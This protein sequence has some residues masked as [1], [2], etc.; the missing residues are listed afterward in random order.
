MGPEEDLAILTILNNTNNKYSANTISKRFLDWENKL[1][2]NN[3]LRINPLLQN[4]NTTAQSNKMVLV[5]E[6]NLIFEDIISDSI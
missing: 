5:E 6:K 4:K 3:S 2:I 1:V